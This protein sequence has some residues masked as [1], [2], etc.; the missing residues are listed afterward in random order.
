[1]T[2]TEPTKRFSQRA[3]NYV[4]YRPG[5][6]VAILDCLRSEC[7]LTSHSVIAD[8]G[9]GTGKLT[10]V[11]LRNGNTV[12]A[13]EPN[14]EMRHE[15]E[16]LLGGFEKFVSVNGRA[17]D[18][19][20]SDNA[21]DLVTAGQAFHWFNAEATRLEFSRVLR[22]G[23]FAA[24]IW[25]AR[26]HEVDPVMSGY[27]QILA[28]HGM[29][30][31]D[32]RHRSHAGDIDALFINGRE[33]RTFPHRRSVDFETLW[34]GFLSSSYAPLPGDPRFEPMKVALRELFET[35]QK[36]GFVTFLYETSLYFGKL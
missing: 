12:Y 25:N 32:V 6:P 36:N 30:Y 26:N 18:T 15:A 34:G 23:G 33:L 31:L 24:L 20:L 17:E 7:G 27:E 11:F 19:T 5:Y 13:V 35:H 14:D 1:V 21:I 8:V 29:G 9:S 28:A 10:E 2:D 4:R 22:T 16:H 3:K